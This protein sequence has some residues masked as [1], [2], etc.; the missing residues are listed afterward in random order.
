MLS[1]LILIN[2]LPL[3]FFI[4]GI[5]QQAF[6]APINAIPKTLLVRHGQDKNQR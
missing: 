6:D 2:P 3:I 1:I 4:I 5:A